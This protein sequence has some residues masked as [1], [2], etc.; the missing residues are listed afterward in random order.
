MKHN[1]L[2]FR[3]FVSIFALFQLGFNSEARAAD[4]LPHGAYYRAEAGFK[5]AQR[6]FAK[7][8][9]QLAGS[10]E[11]HGSPEPYIRHIMA[12]HSRIAGK[13]EAAIGKEATVRPDYLTDEFAERL[14]ANWKKL[15]PGLKLDTLSHESGR[16]LRLAVM[17]TWNIPNSELIAGETTLTDGE[18]NE[19]ARFLAKD[20]FKKAD[21][22]DVDRFYQDGAGYD[23]LSRIS[24]IR[25][26]K[27]I[28]R[29]IMSPEKRI[30]DIENDKRGS[31]AVKLLN[32]H[33]NR[34][35]NYLVSD[36][37]KPV[38]ADHLIAALKSGLRLGEELVDLEGMDEY[39]HDALFYSHVIKEDFAKRFAYIR[40]T[41]K[42][43]EEAEATVRS[44]Y[45][46]VD[47]LAVLANLE[48]RLAIL[49]TEIK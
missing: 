2:I 25:M 46:M 11:Y 6:D 4:P 44:V 47:N 7:I 35:M 32:D 37:A 45:A 30:E 49:E 33:Q 27:R 26:S 20:Y 9:L 13:Y 22:P 19:F 29:G 28:E 36:D 8:L 24:K 31:L 40:K 14:I 23:K 38:G 48:F 39:E 1:P 16:N 10:L 42:P 34:V 18:R 43:Q 41:V 15:T 3:Y 21:L 12:E 17:G 5:P